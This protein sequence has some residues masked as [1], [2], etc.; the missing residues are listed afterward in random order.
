MWVAVK[1]GEVV[2]STQSLTSPSGS[3]SRLTTVVNG[4]GQAVQLVTPRAIPSNVRGGGFVGAGGF[5]GGAGDGA[6]VEGREDGG[7]KPFLAASVCWRFCSR[8]TRA[9][10]LGRDGGG[11]VMRGAW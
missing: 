10:S 6:G 8:L 7:G 9:G 11:V 1:V 3:I 5:G 2:A 4:T